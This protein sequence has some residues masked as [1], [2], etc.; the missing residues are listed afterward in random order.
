MVRGGG[1]ARRYLI[2][3]GDRRDGAQP[4][5]SAAGEGRQNIQDLAVQHGCLPTVDRDL[6]KEKTAPGQHAG[7]TWAM[8]I[9]RPIE[10]L[11]DRAV[12][13]RDIVQ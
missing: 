11:T 7:K 8:T 2:T 12:A 9:G 1:H 6:V 13:G 10:D 3:H 4:A 5:R